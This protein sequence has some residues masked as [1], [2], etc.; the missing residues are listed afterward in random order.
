MI[1]SI[2]FMRSLLAL[3]TILIVLQ[4]IRAATVTPGNSATPD[5]SFN[6]TGLTLV[7]SHS[8]SGSDSLG[9]NFNYTDAVY[10]DSHNVFGNG[11]LDF[12]YQVTPTNFGE[13]SD[14]EPLSFTGFS[15]DVR[16]TSSGSSL[17]GGIFAD[18]TST[19]VS[20]G[21]TSNGSGLDFE[22]NLSLSGT[23]ALVVETNATA[24]DAN[25]RIGVL[26]IADP[27]VAGFEPATAGVPEPATTALFGVGLAGVLLL[28][29]RL[30]LRRH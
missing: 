6:M 5:S 14:V 26:F 23:V 22:L 15:T 8:G 10:Q 19:P 25:G 13:P 11:D 20:V 18:G 28:R 16:Y 2:T 12:V 7:T 29:R 24:S 17:P 21:R 3:S 4:P 30:G 9:N 27:G 1:E